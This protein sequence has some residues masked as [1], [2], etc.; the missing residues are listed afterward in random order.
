MN[1]AF[2]D[3]E[4]ELRRGVRRI[5]AGGQGHVRRRWR[6]TTVFTV[7][8]A[9]AV[10]GAAVAAVTHFAHHSGSPNEQ[11]A[12]IAARAVRQSSALPACRPA[13]TSALS[14]L[15]DETP[16]RTVTS[17]LPI[18]GQ[19]A[20]RPERARALTIANRF[21]RRTTILGRRGPG[22]TLRRSLHALALGQGITEF[23][24]LN[25]GGGFVRTARDPARCAE[26]RMRLAA[27]L[28]ADRP[29]VVRR[30]IAIIL[31]RRP[32][33]DS[34]VVTLLQAVHLRGAHATSG[35]GGP[36]GRH[37]PVHIGLQL[38]ATAPHGTLLVGIAPP[39]VTR[40]LVHAHHRRPGLPRTIRP[41]H[42]FFGLIAPTGTGPMTARMLAADGSLVAVVKLP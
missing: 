11:A 20:P 4:R 38:S 23:V 5:A 22:V 30:H 2:D 39:A 31:R 33:I 25:R 13:D 34:G 35:G 6:R 16:P 19:L 24:W 42:G 28:A 37:N 36:I 18:L 32:D 14:G 9:I 7:A 8:A 29:P 26:L 41:H 40:I 10:S 15:S 27:R 21:T 12:T 3:L 17:V 1:D